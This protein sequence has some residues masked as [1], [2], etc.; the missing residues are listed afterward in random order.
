ARRGGEEDLLKLL[1]ETT[2]ND[3]QRIKKRTPFGELKHHAHIGV[4]VSTILGEAI[5]NLSSWVDLLS[6]DRCCL[7]G[8]NSVSIRR[9]L[10]PVPM[11]LQQVPMKEE[12]AYSLREATQPG[13][14][15]APRLLPHSESS[16][17]GPWGIPL[18]YNLS[19]P[20]HK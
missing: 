9:L 3:S 11:W 17:D 8:R 13:A 4:T 10:Y 19:Q 12:K 5:L 16:G 6:W 7:S 2:G 18:P 14:R 20:N 15:V 1:Q